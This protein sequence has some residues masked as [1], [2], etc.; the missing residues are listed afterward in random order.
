MSILRFDEV[1]KKVGLSR[2]TVWRMERDG[3]FPRRV[4]LGKNSVGWK[5]QDVDEWVESRERVG[6]DVAI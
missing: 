4:R 3:L 5:S 2:P 6:G 1:K